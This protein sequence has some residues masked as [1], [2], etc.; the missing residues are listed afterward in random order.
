MARTVEK[1]LAALPRVITIKEFPM[2]KHNNI[3]IALGFLTGLALSATAF[4][5]E[6]ETVASC[7]ELADRSLSKSNM[8]QYKLE[9]YDAEGNLFGKSKRYTWGDKSFA[10]YVGGD[11]HVEIVYK[12]GMY[13][14]V[15]ENGVASEDN[16]LSPE[17]ALLVIRL[18]EQINQ[19]DTRTPVGMIATTVSCD[20]GWTGTEP[21]LSACYVTPVIDVP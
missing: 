17:A 21:T 8:R 12:R 9:A 15:F 6:G 4:A 7:T 1:N 19:S 3:M 5:D 10:Q 18:Q 13:F 11:T 14:K 20:V 2:F 16:Y